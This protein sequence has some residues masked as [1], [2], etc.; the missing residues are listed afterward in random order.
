MK[1]ELYAILYQLDL[2]EQGCTTVDVDTFLSLLDEVQDAAI[3]DGNSQSREVNTEEQQITSPLLDIG[4][5]HPTFLKEP[6]GLTLGLEAPSNSSNL[7]NQNTV[8]QVPVSFHEAIKEK[9]VKKQVFYNILNINQD[10][11]LHIY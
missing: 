5:S 8:H 3:D 9:L 1:L 2:K 10:T 6:L 7:L 11:I 4:T